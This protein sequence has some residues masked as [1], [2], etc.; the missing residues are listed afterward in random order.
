MNCSGSKT[1][2]PLWVHSSFNPKTKESPVN[3]GK[4]Y[5][6]FAHNASLV[7]P[8]N[9]NLTHHRI[10]KDHMCRRINSNVKC[11]RR[12]WYRNS[13]LISSTTHQSKHTFVVISSMSLQSHTTS[14]VLKLFR[15]RPKI[16]TF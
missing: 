4:R 9:A 13:V 14:V 7:V 10:Y 5:V 8:A 12:L 3:A 16:N 2:S 11:S 6:N 15:T 1:T